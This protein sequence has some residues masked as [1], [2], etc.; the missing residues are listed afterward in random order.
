MDRMNGQRE[1]EEPVP[2]AAGFRRVALVNVRIESRQ[3]SPV[4][5]LMLAAC[6]QDRA[7]TIIFDPDPDDAQLAEIVAFQPDL[8]GIGFMTQ[9]RFRALEINRILRE[10]LPNAKFV[11][12]GVGPTVEPDKTF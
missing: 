3:R 10:K 9:T 4:G 12:G 11:L 6:I 7:R 1:P 5:L 2:A 8:V